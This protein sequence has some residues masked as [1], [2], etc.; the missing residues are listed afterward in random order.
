MRAGT[1]KRGGALAWTLLAPAL[2]AIGSGLDLS[3]GGLVPSALG[4]YLIGLP[5][6]RIASLGPDLDHGGSRAGRLAPG[7]S[8]V[9]GAILGG[10]RGGMHSFLSIG[11]A[12]VIG[13]LIGW[14]L[15]PLTFGIYPVSV[16]TST[17]AAAAAAGWA[18]HLV[19]D[20][21]TPMGQMLLW[22]V[23]RHR[24]PGGPIPCSPPAPAPMRLGEFLTNCAILCA[25]AIALASLFGL[26]A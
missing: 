4:L 26:M 12:Y 7:V 15:A 25:L 19:L 10:H 8:K 13:A 18:S 21:M 1:H 6:A 14:M 11:L 20:Q 17:F 24:I 16:M 5:V 2:P 23:L 3:Q 9:T 22:P